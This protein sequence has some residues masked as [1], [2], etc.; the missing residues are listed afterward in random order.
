[1]TQ[2]PGF[3]DPNAT[4]LV[5]KLNKALYGL[6]K[7][8]RA[9]FDKLKSA[10]FACGFICS[11][12]DNS[13]FIRQT[14][15][16]TTHILLYVDD[17]LITGTSTTAIQILISDL[18]KAFALKDLGELNYFLGIQVEHTSNGLHLCQKK[19]ITDVLTKA[20]LQYA[21][22]LGTPM[23]GGEKLSSFGSDPIQGPHHYRSL[24]G[25]LQY[26]TITRPEIS[27]AVNRVSQFMHIPLASHWKI[28]KWILR[29]LKGTLDFGLHL[30]TCSK[31][32][33]TA[34]CDVDWASDPDDRRS[35]SGLCVYLGPNLVSW[36][37]K[38]Q[39]TI[40]RSS[41]E[42]EYRS[43]AHVTTKVTWVQSLLFE[44]HLHLPRAPTIWC[45]NLSTVLMSANPVLHAR[46]K[47]IELDLYFVCEKVLNKS[48]VVKHTPAHDQV[49][50]I[51]TKALSPSRFFL[52]RDKL[53]V[54]SSQFEGEY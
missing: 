18:H 3:E 13:L 16:H 14:N 24:V 4:S 26:E 46:T 29:Y 45:D 11:K 8:P 47:H 39:S 27:Y 30:Q 44:L 21:N 43:L 9:R 10:L 50:D 34:F 52:L 54:L 5:C 41:T 23:T 19:Y 51:L 49:T 15:L 28:V 35:T 33:L 37:S 17:I 22:S 12:A 42:A 53:R 36:S 31:L 2:P 1:M 40:S 48:I 6:R 38:K 7:A 20:K 25:A 32:S